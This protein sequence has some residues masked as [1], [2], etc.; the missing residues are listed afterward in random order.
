M[1]EKEEKKEIFEKFKILLSKIKEREK[2]KKND[3]RN[4]LIR[5]RRSKSIKKI[6]SQIIEIN[7][8]TGLLESFVERKEYLFIEDENSDSDIVKKMKDLKEEIEKF[9]KETEYV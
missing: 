9:L 5:K 1:K 8:I 2:I 6:E 3:Y 7:A 4:L